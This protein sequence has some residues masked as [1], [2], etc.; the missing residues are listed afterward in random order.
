LERAP[1]VIVDDGVVRS[2]GQ[3]ILGA[4]DKAAVAVLLLLVRDLVRETPAADLEVVFTAG[5]EMGLQG[6]NALAPD[7]VSAAT[8]FVLDSSGVPGTV[9]TSAP[10]LTAVNAEF[11]ASRRTQV[12]SPRAA[13]APC[14]RRLG[15]SAGCSSAAWITRLRPT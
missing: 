13:E 11:R 6:A 1:T 14:S 2:D 12:S 9:I 10:T 3:T 4:D 7:A 8:V 15:R 5:E